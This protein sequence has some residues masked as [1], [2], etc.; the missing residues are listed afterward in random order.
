MDPLPVIEDL[1]LVEDFTPCLFSS[2]ERSAVGQFVL[3]AAEKTLRSG[4]VP[5][6][7]LA[8]HAGIE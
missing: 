7:L 1:D 8:A 3:E 5:R 4:I 6:A 2:F